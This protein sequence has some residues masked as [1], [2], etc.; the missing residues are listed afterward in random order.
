[1]TLIEMKHREVGPAP[2]STVKRVERG[3]RIGLLPSDTGIFHVTVNYI[4]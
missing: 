3:R 2:I 4:L 1:M